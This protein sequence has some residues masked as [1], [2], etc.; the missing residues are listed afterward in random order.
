MENSITRAI[1]SHMP[2]F[3]QNILCTV[4]GYTARRQR[5]G[6]D[7]FQLL[8]FLGDSQ[9]YSKSDFERLQYESL[10][11]LLSYCYKFNSFYREQFK[12]LGLSP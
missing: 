1:Y 3:V 10:Q 6:K 9:W 12:K 5:Y 8:D 7:F 2:P 4:A 11:E